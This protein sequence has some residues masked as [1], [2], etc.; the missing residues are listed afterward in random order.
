MLDRMTAVI[1]DISRSLLRCLLG[2]GAEHA[3]GDRV[4]GR[5]VVCA[6]GPDTHHS[7]PP[8]LRTGPRPVTRSVH[9][10]HMTGRA[11]RRPAALPDAATQPRR[12]SHRRRRQG[13]ACVV[14]RVH[15]QRH[16]GHAGP[17]HA[18]RTTAQRNRG[19]RRPARGPVGGGARRASHHRAHHSGDEGAV[20]RARYGSTVTIVQHVVHPG[21]G[22]RTL[23]FPCARTR[24]RVADMA[25]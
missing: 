9:R 23:G 8:W 24:W 2:V 18:R 1:H 12:G 7:A 25:T 21:I 13:G 19:D 20:G 4:G 11:G 16:D 15:D 6:A 10:A 14:A 17:G 22:C 3:G 5:P